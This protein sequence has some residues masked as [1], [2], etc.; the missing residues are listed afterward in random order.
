MKFNF[1]ILIFVEFIIKEYF[2]G[3]GGILCKVL[4]DVESFVVRVRS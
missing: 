2:V 4:G 3:V 1:R